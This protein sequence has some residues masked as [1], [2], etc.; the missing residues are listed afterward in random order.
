MFVFRQGPIFHHLSAIDKLKLK[1]WQKSM[2]NITDAE[3][4]S[5]D[6]D[7]LKYHIQEVNLP[8]KVENNGT[9]Q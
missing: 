8:V 3:I 5:F 4:I 1:D 7:P 9:K 2:A 6:P